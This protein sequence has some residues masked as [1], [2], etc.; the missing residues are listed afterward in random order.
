MLARLGGAPL[1]WAEIAVMGFSGIGVAIKLTR[2]E[3]FQCACLGTALNVPLTSVT[4]IE[5][6]GMA[7]LALVLLLSGS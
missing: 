1:L 3:Q 6:F 4:L 2:G 5:D 7:A